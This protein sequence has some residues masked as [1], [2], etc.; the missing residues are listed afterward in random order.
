VKIRANI[1]AVALLWTLAAGLHLEAA[2]YTWSGGPGA[3]GDAWRNGNNWNPSSGAGGPGT[4]DVAIFSSAGTA[5]N[6]GI[7]F[8]DGR[9]LVAPI[10]TIVLSAGGN[11]TIFNSSGNAAGTL[12]VE[13]LNGQLLLN[14]ASNAT[15]ALTDGLSQAMNVDFASGGSIHVDASNSA[16]VIGSA[17]SG[18]NG[19]VKTG[20]GLLRLNGVNSLGGPVTVA[21]GELALAASAGASLGSVTNVRVQSGASLRLVTAEQLGSATDLDLAGGTLRGALGNVAVE[22]TAGRL[23]LSADSVVDLRASAIT[24]A[25]SSSVTW[26]SGTI[27]NITNWRNVGD[28]LGGRI[29]FGVGGLTSTQLAQVYF[30]DLGI[31]GAQLVG[32]EG[33]LMPIPEA[34]VAAA[35]GALVGLIVWRERRRLL[36]AVQHRLAPRAGVSVRPADRHHSADG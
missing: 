20:S 30:A 31:H 26:G 23:T 36:R 15:L 8:N 5:T 11:R 12:R 18:S 6:I 24:F 14:Q 21:G 19:F 32:P 27:L 10:G 17:I 28:P 35:A 4:G 25:N 34:P 9:G 29:Y 2:P 7:N 3:G 33:E 22:E 13:S 1:P 16:I